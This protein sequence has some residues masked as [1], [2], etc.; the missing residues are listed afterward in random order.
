M[1]PPPELL[2][3]PMNCV[4]SRF[5]RTSTNKIKCPI[6][7]VLVSWCNVDLSG[8]QGPVSALTPGII[9][10]APSQW[11]TTLHCNLVSHWL[12]AYTKWSLNSLEH[13]LRMKFMSTCEI[14]LGWMPQNVL[15]DKSALVWVM[16]FCLMAPCHYM[17]Q[18]CFISDKVLWH[19]PESVFNE[20]MKQ[21]KLQLHLSESNR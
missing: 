8:T 4:T 19:S 10:H 20:D 12:G 16:A 9:L 18:C 13:L 14:A 15:G 1:V 7:C 3:T 17:N 21:G 6:F 11:E 5:I 2:D